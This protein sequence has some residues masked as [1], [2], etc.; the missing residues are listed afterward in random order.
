MRD[1]K[2]GQSQKLRCLLTFRNEGKEESLKAFEQSGSRIY[3]MFR[4]MII[5]RV[6][7]SILQVKEC[8]KAGEIGS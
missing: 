1:S 4:K 2:V 3:L 7:K 5:P 6:S 8:C